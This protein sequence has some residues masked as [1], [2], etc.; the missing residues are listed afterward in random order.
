[1]AYIRDGLYMIIRTLMILPTGMEP[2]KDPHA[3]CTKAEKSQLSFLF[4]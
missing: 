4:F 2:L 3:I 1:M